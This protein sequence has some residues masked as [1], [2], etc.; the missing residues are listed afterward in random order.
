[1]IHS[2]SGIYKMTSFMNCK[3]VSSVLSKMGI[4]KLFVL[5][6]LISM[7]GIYS[8]SLTRVREDHEHDAE[9][10]AAIQS[11]GPQIIS[12]VWTEANPESKNIYDMFNIEQLVQ[13]FKKHGYDPSNLPNIEDI[14]N[15]M[16]EVIFKSCNPLFNV[17]IV[18]LK[19]KN[20]LSRVR[21]KRFLSRTSRHTMGTKQKTG[22]AG[23]QGSAARPLEVLVTFDD[24]NVIREIVR[25]Q[26]LFLNTFFSSLSGCIESED[27]DLSVCL[28][29]AFSNAFSLLTIEL[30]E[31]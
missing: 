31:N 30:G 1:M 9:Q 19:H 21:E 15:V 14:S 13:C 28:L 8:L 29:E 3:V 22:A 7:E 10:D 27:V 26:F 4:R 18:A 23:N 5:F 17:P 24:I 12:D 11:V 20:Q 16:K 2:K 6:F 25:L